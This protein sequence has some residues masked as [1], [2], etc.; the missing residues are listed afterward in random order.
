[1]KGAPDFPALLKTNDQ[2]LNRKNN[3]FSTPSKGQHQKLTEI[4][5]HIIGFSS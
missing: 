5:T 3:N 4:N 2:K 1:M